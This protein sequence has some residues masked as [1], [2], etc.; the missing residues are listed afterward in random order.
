MRNLSDEFIEQQNIGNH[1]YQKFVDITL[2]D[3]NVLHLT[4]KHL[5]SNG[6]SFEDSVSSQDNFDIGSAIVNKFKIVLNN[7]YDEFS[8]YV[9]AG[10][11]AVV[12]VGLQLSSGIEKIRICTGILSEEP[13]QRS[14]V[15]T[16][17]FLDNMSKFDKDYSGVKTVFPATRNQIVRDICS[18]CGVTLQTVTFDDDD[19]IIQKRPIDE[20]LTCRQMLAWVAQI[21]CQWAKC[22]EYGKL[23][24]SWYK[25]I[26]FGEMEV[27]SN[28]SL[29]VYEQVFGSVRTEVNIDKNQYDSAYTEKGIFDVEDGSLVYLA[30]EKSNRPI[31]I[32]KMT[33]FSVDLEDVVITGVKVTEY[34]E[35]S[36]QENPAKTYLYGNEGY[37]LNISGN[38]LIS[39]G[40][41]QTISGMIG[42]KCVGMRFRPFQA[43]CLTDISI[44][45]GDPIIITDRKGNVF[46]SFITNVSLR[47]GDFQ[48]LSCGAKSAER[49]SAKQYSIITQV[50][51]EARQNVEREKTERE[52][53]LQNL[54]DRISQSSGSFTTVQE[55]ETGGKIFYLHN[56]PNLKD[57]NFVW[58]MTAEAWAVSTDGGKTWNGG[59]TVDGDTIVRILTATGVNA[60]W[61]NTG[62]ITVRDSN[63]N[64]IFSVDMDTKRVIISGDSVQIGGKPIQ[65][66]INTGI[67]ESKKYSDKKLSDYAN[68]VTK[69][70]ENLQSQVDG[71][72]EDWYFD[73]EPS[74]QNRPASEWTT[75]I[76]R[77]KHVGDRFF[78]KSRGYAYRFMENNGVWG[79]VLLK[80]TD[81]T[82][83]MQTAQNA[84]DTA[85]GKRRTFIT[86]P[87]PP[88][89]IGDMWANGTDILTCSVSRASGTS[90]V[91]TDW[92]KLNKYTDDTV[93][94]QALEEAKNAMDGFTHENIF[95]LFTENGKNQGFYK[96][97]GQ[98]YINSTY[99]KSG[100]FVAGGANN[101]NGKIEVRD[102][103]N[104]VIGRWDKDGIYIESGT[105]VSKNQDKKNGVEISGGRAKFLYDSS[106][107]G[108]I[109][110]NIA[111]GTSM[112]GLVFDLEID[113]KF[114]LWAKKIN[115]NENLF[116]PVMYYSKE[117]GILDSLEESVSVAT[118]LDLRSFE[119]KRAWI[120]DAKIRNSFK[121]PNDTQCDIYSNV[122]FHSWRIKNAHL[123]SIKGIN[124][125]APYSGKFY[126]NTA[127]TPQ[128]GATVIVRDGIITAVQKGFN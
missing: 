42:E 28:G 83:A 124:G 93:A 14:S 66:A 29:R 68:T 20:A 101:Q 78:W 65:D 43:S 125:V 117:Q 63:Q 39:E 74:M 109:G 88:Y 16:L 107:V 4:N 40:T 1:N 47:P 86:Q 115:P 6:F 3:G 126:A 91:S 19:Y 35:N 37:V 44:E 69:D 112:A 57:S 105:I 95:D 49:N 30:G 24:L 103:S 58:K 51:V 32:R 98:I 114:M 79:W 13:K 123:E 71:Q 92:E 54:S 22:D 15:I 80:D 84:K 70:I 72:V 111:Q 18:Y 27:D 53:A 33:D 11:T 102:S 82:K 106:D 108:Y 17:Q 61:I 81:I 34:K 10:A 2:K 7:I 87:V 26:L 38:K 60:D 25:D 67:S 46:N 113:G 89:D 121:I 76:E 59:M 41:G 5:W 9:F 64:I 127:T 100:T 75:T 85:D 8:D 116:T 52:K 31:N 55:D 36:T 50:E 90:Y 48:S 120:V 45:A 94:N 128:Y 12:Y 110:T 104:R 21:G 62:A 122:D 96:E 73:Y 119:L 77:Q 118:N 97:N 56:K 99:I 23:C